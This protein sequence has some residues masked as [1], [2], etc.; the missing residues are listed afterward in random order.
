MSRM[1][2][3]KKNIAALVGAV[4]AALCFL[5][6]GALWLLLSSPSTHR[7]TGTM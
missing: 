3:E 7:N 5:V 1:I 2:K 4:A 6:F